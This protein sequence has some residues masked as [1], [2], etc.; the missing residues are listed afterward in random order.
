MALTGL[1]LI[2]FVIGHLVGNLQIFENPDRINGY[3]H[4]LRQLGP[5]LWVA[6]IGLLVCLV[7]HVWAATVLAIEDRRARGP[8]PYKK[9]RWL[10]ATIASRYTRWTGYVVLAF[11]VYHLAQFTWGVAQS[12]QF[13]EALPLYTMTSDYQF[14]GF[15]VVP[16][17]T[18]VYDVHSMVVLGF[19]NW[20]VSIFYIIAVGLLAIHLRHGADSLFQTLGLRSGRWGGGLRA[21]VLVFS[22]LYF[23]GNLIIPGA[24]LIGAKGLREGYRGP[25]AT[26][27]AHR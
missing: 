11:V 2:G 13:K 24:V 14:A 17:G 18:Q 9:N 8:V 5:L 16:A 26:M 6:R 19:Q 7:I 3:A 12:S 10:D 15:P 4:F 21:V 25:T 23:I 27:A 1:V 20:I 22:I